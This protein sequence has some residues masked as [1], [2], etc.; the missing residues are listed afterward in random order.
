MKLLTLAL[1]PV[2]L[3]FLLQDHLHEH[4]QL[5]LKSFQLPNAQA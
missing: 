3:Y 2:V 1:L 4:G 5:E